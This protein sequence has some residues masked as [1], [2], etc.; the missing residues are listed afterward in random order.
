MKF[1]FE[2][3]TVLVTGASRGIGRAIAI[4]FAKSEANVLV[5]Y[6]TNQ[7]AAQET[8][9]L[10]EGG[11]HQLIQADMADPKSI[12]QMIVDLKEKDIRIDLLVNNAGIYED[13]DML[14]MNYQE[15]QDAWNRTINTNLNGVAHLSFLCVQQMAENGGGKIINITSRG[16]FRGEPTAPAYGAAKSG[17]NSF[18]QSMAKA[19]AEKNIFIYTIAPG[20]VE[21]DM[22]IDYLKTD[23]G[24]DIKAQSPLNRVAKP[25]EIANAV[26]F[27]ASDNN[28][29]LTGCIIDINGASYLRN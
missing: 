5:H 2:G 19:L 10:L 21:T 28:D 11:N 16:A 12:E 8:L 25:E 24:N 4:L 20:W 1:S 29:Y 3:K 26:A 27:C 7:E 22:S 14:N 9:S 15:W 23:A 17:L 18:G 13:I 6:H